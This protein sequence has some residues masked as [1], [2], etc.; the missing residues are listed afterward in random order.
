MAKGARFVVMILTV[1]AVAGCVSMPSSGPVG[2]YGV[3]QGSGDTDQQYLQVNVTSPGAGW[4]PLQIVQGFL[5]ANA[6]FVNGHQVAR[7]YLTDREAASWK[8]TWSATVFSGT[9]PKVNVKQVSA[10]TAQVTVSGAVEANVRQTGAYIVPQ[11]E[12]GSQ[13]FTIDLTKSGDDWRIAGA[14]STLLLSEV[15]FAA[16]YQSRD[17]YFLNPAKTS[18][19]ADPIYVPIEAVRA[20]DPDGLLNELVTDLLQQP[21]DWLANGATVTAFPGGT[22]VLS[23]TLAGGTATVNL[24]GKISQQ[25]LQPI[26]AQ[27]LWTL[28]GSDSQ[29]VVSGVQLEIDGKPWTQGNSGVSVLQQSQSA[30]EK[31]APP[32]GSGDGTFYYLDSHGDI[33]KQ[34]GPNGAA[35]RV[36]TQNPS[37]PIRFTTIAVSPDQRYVAA[38]A[39]GWVYTA[40]VGGTPVRRIQGDFSSL[41]WDRSDQLWMA[42]NSGVEVVSKTSA[43]ANPVAVDTAETVTALRVAPDGVRVALVLNG[44][45]LTFGAISETGSGATID[46]SPFSVISA[47]ITSV[48]WY[49]ASNVIAL[50]GAG[51][52][53]VATEYPVDG[54][55]STRIQSAPGMAN[56]TASWGY[57]LI[58]NPGNGYMSYNESV[59]G[60]WI[61]LTVTGISATYPG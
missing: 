9:G 12:Q 23:V 8:V 39:G 54:G 52:G 26:A 50:S 3:T 11:T 16:D 13:T 55:V 32:Q 14:P 5:A 33:V 38:I 31:Y 1:L 20:A 41:S 25:D 57:P 21:T 37:H 6:S 18:L 17:L 42:G 56:I 19:V 59:N 48:T 30:F 7:E 58:S 36:Y 44:T 15:D 10:H 49:G 60:A 43:T 4:G 28:G 34:D 53:A 27:L 24:S 46:E 61:S 47:T 45:T 29:P 40:A 2:E 51:A 35:T 22:K